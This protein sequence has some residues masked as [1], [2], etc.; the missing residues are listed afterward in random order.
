MGLRRRLEYLHK[1]GPD[2]DENTRNLYERILQILYSKVQAA[3]TIIQS[4]IKDSKEHSSARGILRTGKAKASK[5][6]L[7]IKESLQSA[8]QELKSWESAS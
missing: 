1:V 7:R 3:I 5:Y 4:M 2:L 6:A 8:I